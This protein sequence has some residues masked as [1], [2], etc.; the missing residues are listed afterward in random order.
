M[1][2]EIEMLRGLLF[3]IFTL[4]FLASGTEILNPLKISHIAI[5]NSCK[6]KSTFKVIRN[7]VI[8]VR[9]KTILFSSL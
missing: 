9:K 6:A 3:S 7:G 2:L 1:R 5:V 8:S 4:Y